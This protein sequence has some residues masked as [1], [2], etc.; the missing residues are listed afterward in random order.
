MNVPSALRRWLVP[1]ALAGAALG[2]CLDPIVSTPTEPVPCAA[3]FSTARCE[4]IVAWVTGELGIEPS[5]IDGVDIVPSPPEPPGQIGGTVPITLRVH[6]PDGPARDV[7][8]H[9]FGTSP[10]FRSECM[11]DPHVE[12]VYATG[13]GSGYH[14]T[15]VGSTPFPDPDPAAAA[16]AV[17]LLIDRQ[18]ISVVQPG[19]TRVVLG[20][21]LLANGIIQALSFELADD[22]P[23]TVVLRGNITLEVTPAAGGGPIWN[24]YE[25]GWHDGVEAVEV[26]ITFNAAILKAGASFEIVNLIVR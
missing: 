11:D 4:A 20:Q 21:A 17:P 3:S 24:I 12:L 14:D 5:G 19:V 25:H 13:P 8:M 10:A 18:T 1:V 9:C 15:P 6:L 26:A 23:D 7:A 22:W 16:R 2:G